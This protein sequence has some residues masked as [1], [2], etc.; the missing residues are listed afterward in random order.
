[1]AQQQADLSNLRE[2]AAMFFRS[3][4]LSFSDG[5]NALLKE[6][7]KQDQTGDSMGKTINTI[8][9]NNGLSNDDVLAFEKALEY[10]HDKEQAEPLRI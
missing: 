2:G 7:T 5:M 10:T 6:A 3:Y 4:G 8:A 1:M 9:R